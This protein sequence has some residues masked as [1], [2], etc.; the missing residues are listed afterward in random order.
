MAIRYV[1]NRQYPKY[2]LAHVN[3]ELSLGAQI[4]LPPGA[5]IMGGMY[6]VVQPVESGTA[7]ITLTD[8]G[9]TPHNYLS[10]VSMAS[11]VVPPLRHASRKAATRGSPASDFASG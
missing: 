5:I 3:A 9:Q 8:N 6:T 1:N 4:I 2:A 11:S 10:A 7:T